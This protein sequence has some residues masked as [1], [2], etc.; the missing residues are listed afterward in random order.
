M[1]YS[2]SGLTSIGSSNDGSPNEGLV[3]DNLDGIDPKFVDPTN[4]DFRVLPGSP[5]V[6]AAEVLPD[7]TDDFHGVPRP[8]VP[9]PDIGPY[10]SP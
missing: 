5:A 3:Q 6:G 1:F 8:E 10:Q 9:A 4:G 2:G 7:V